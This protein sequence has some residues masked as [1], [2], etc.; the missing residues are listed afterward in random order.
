MIY[1]VHVQGVEYVYCLLIM[2]DVRLGLASFS[3]RAARNM[4]STASKHFKAGEQQLFCTAIHS[5]TGSLESIPGLGKR[6]LTAEEK[7]SEMSVRRDRIRTSHHASL[8]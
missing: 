8:A 4:T 3:A 1:L 2:T 5:T 7:F 6:H